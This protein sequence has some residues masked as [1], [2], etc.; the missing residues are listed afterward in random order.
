MLLSKFP[1]PF[2][3]ASLLDS[4]LFTYLVI[5][6]YNGSYYGVLLVMWVRMSQ[7]TTTVRTIVDSKSA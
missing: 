3:D 6:T 7:V 2:N 1:L 4:M 5:P